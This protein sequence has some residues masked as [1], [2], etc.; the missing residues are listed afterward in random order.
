MPGSA[1]TNW[2]KAVFSPAAV[3]DEYLGVSGGGENNA[4]HVSFDFFRQDGTA[5]YNRYQRGTV[6]VNT[7]FNLDRLNVGENIGLAL[8]QV[9]GGLADDPGGY[10]EDGILGKNILMQPVVPVYDIGG[11][12]A[13]GKSV[14]LGNNSNPL[15]YASNR[16]FDRNTNDRMFGSVYGGLDVT[17]GLSLKTRLGFNLSQ[18]VF[19]GYNPITPENS[20]PGRANS[21]DETNQQTTDCTWSNT[22]NYSRTFD[23]HSLAV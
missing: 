21:I 12:F 17:K 1:E 15:G 14:S 8:E 6:R 10:A 2:W 23:R 3:A 16:Q 13:S 19:R 9:Y 22:L 20:E 11:H 7:A 4:Y 18:Q 5:A